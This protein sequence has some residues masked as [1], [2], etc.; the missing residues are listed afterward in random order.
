[1]TVTWRDHPYSYDGFLAVLNPATVLAAQVDYTHT[2]S[3]GKLAGTSIWQ[4]VFFDTVTVGDT[5]A[6]G[7]EEGM[8]L[9]LGSSAGADD[10]G[11]CRVRGVTTVNVGGTNYTVLMVWASPNKADGGLYIYNTTIHLSVFLD[12]RVWM[13]APY[14][15]GA[16]GYFD[17]TI[18]P[19]PATWKPAPKANAGPGYAGFVDATTGLATVSFSGAN[20]YATARDAVLGAWG[21][22]I[23]PTATITSSSEN[24]THYDH[25]VVDGN[26]TTYWEATSDQN[27]YLIFTFAAAKKIKKFSLTCTG[28]YAPYQF[29]LRKTATGSAN[30][31]EYFSTAWGTNETRTFYVDYDYPDGGLTVFRLYVQSSDGG[32]GY[33]VRIKEVKF[34]EEDRATAYTWGVDSTVTITVGSTT[35]EAI[36][37]TFPP[38]WHWVKLTVTD[39]LTM[40]GFVH[41]PVYAGTRDGLGLINPAGATLT[42]STEKLGYPKEA[43]FDSDTGTAWAATA[44][45]GSLSIEYGAAQSVGEAVITSGLIDTWSSTIR[46]FSIDYWNGSAWVPVA[47]AAD[48][49]PTT[50]YGDAGNI[51]Y[52]ATFTPVTAAKWRINITDSNAEGTSVGVKELA[53]Y[54]T[55]APV[56]ITDFEVTNQVLGLGGQKLSVIIHE[57]LPLDTYPDGTLVMYWEEEYYGGVQGS[58]STAGP[59]GREHVKFIGWIDTEPTEIVAESFDTRTSTTFDCVDVGGRLAQLPAFSLMFERVTTTPGYLYELYGANLDRC[60]Y[61]MLHYMS[62]ACELADFFGT[63]LGDTWGVSILAMQSGTLFSSIDERAQAIAYRFTCDK[64]GRLRLIEDPMLKGTTDHGTS[65]TLALTEADY[66]SLTY[67]H[68]RPSR[69]HW[70]W[71]SSI[72]AY[73]LEVKTDVSFVISTYFCIVPGET[74]GQG[75]SSEDH[76]EQLGTQFQLNWREGHRYAARLN[77]NDSNLE[78]GLCH[79]GDYG[80]DPA[81]MMWVSLTLTSDHAP[82]R[83]RTFSAHPALLYELRIVHDH[84]AKTKTVSLTMELEVYGTSAVTYTPPA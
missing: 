14:Y 46:D 20:S 74:P 64:L 21:S 35:T 67:T 76:G 22:D 73:I 58:L 59:S 33:N 81:Q 39:S 55:G 30:V 15:I 3:S 18:G 42:A 27:E 5:S 41:V 83:G 6:T 60:I 65:I 31:G 2:N 24:G 12:Y 68:T 38:G 54:Q 61:I 82:V 43:A 40:T 19:V 26:T 51:P 1:M 16:S 17:G 69:Y 79:A 49:P 78:M 48:L 34:Y 56:P 72:D 63:K 8:T 11:R 25:L 53:F 44:N 28:L 13:K 70:L 84:A 37:A 29:Q 52:V 4:Y 45:T 71:G 80:L 23:A 36:T 47:S 75:A 57:D 9:I 77:A 50:W 10:L 62:T 32:G 66:S 7:V